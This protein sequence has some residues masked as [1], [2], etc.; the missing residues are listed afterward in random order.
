MN[1]N[2][3]TLA[4]VLITLGIIGVVAALTLPSLIAKYQKQQTITRLK[5]A[6]SVLYNAYNLSQAEN[7]LARD[8]IEPEA[9]VYADNV[10]F[11]QNYIGQYLYKASICPGG[12]AKCAWSDAKYMDGSPALLNGQSVTYKLLDG[13][14]LRFWLFH[15]M[16]FCYIWVDTNGPKGPNTY[17]KDIFYFRMDYGYGPSPEG[18]GPHG[19]TNTREENLSECE[20]TGVDCAALIMK[21][22]WEINYKF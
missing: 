18:F 8:W 2:A 4:E 15:A 11:L 12:N 13:T 19:A 3:F 22:G 6:Y 14:F 7:G 9:N 1:K 20:T 10:N 16:H 5:K 21:D 17:G